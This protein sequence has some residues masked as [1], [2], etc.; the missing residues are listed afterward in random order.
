MLDLRGAESFGDLW[1]GQLPRFVLTAQSARETPPEQDKTR[2]YSADKKPVPG[3]SANDTTFLLFFR[4][5]PIEIACLISGF[6]APAYEVRLRLLD[7]EGRTLAEKRQRFDGSHF[8]RMTWRLPADALG[9]YRVRANVVA[10]GPS[11]PSSPPIPETA[12]Q[13]ELSL[14]VIEP[15]ALPAGSEFGW[16]LGPHDADVGLVPLADLLCQGGVCR[17]K[18]PFAVQEATVLPAEAGSQGKIANPTKKDLKSVSADS[19]EP[20][21]SFSDRL[22]MAGIGLVG[23][24]QPP[25]TADNDAKPS[26]ALFAAEAF[27]RDP[28]TW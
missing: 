23:V 17:V 20:L 13:A 9:F 19:L 6:A 2:N 7:F 3:R 15:Q 12:P 18:F 11:G 10:V 22:A 8:A 25:R 24:L 1:L 26:D 4:G 27:A 5:Q 28:K 21:I 14:A 16:S